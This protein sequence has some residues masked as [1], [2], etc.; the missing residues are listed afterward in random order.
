M[1]ST[2]T[3]LTPTSTTYTTSTTLTPTT[4]TTTSPLY[5]SPTQRQLQQQGASV[6]RRPVFFE[7]GEASGRRGDADLSLR[8]SALVALSSAPCPEDRAK[9]LHHR[10]VRRRTLTYQT[11]GMAGIL[12]LASRWWR[13]RLQNKVPCRKVRLQEDFRSLAASGS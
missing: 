1:G 6:S 5:P 9:H 11:N 10:L 13:T 2:P 4:S 3:T 7:K 8:V 12:L